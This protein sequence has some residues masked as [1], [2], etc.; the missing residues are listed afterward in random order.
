MITPSEE[1]KGRGWMPSPAR[2]DLQQSHD[3]FIR[4]DGRFEILWIDFSSGGNPRASALSSLM[5]PQ[6][7]IQVGQEQEA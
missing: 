7:A 3:H 4:K 5:V 2:P 1:K 6:K